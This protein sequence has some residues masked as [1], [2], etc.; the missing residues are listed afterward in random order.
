M[1]ALLLVLVT[2]GADP[3]RPV[4]FDTE[5][6]P[7]LTRAGCNTALAMER[8]SAGAG[9]VSHFWGVIPRSIS[10]RSFMI[11]KAVESTSNIPS[12][13]C[14]SSNPPKGSNTAAASGSP[15]SDHRPSACTNGSPREPRAL[16]PEGW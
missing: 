9:S 5:I 8:P 12:E 14:S 4:D 10:S 16:S 13:A 1:I 6:V 15:L 11:S 7:V 2:L 3:D